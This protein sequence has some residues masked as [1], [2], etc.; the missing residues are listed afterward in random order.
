MSLIKKFENNDDAIDELCACIAI[1]GQAID[2]NFIVL[3]YIAHN[4]P[5]HIE[6]T[7]FDHLKSFIALISNSKI[8][9][10]IITR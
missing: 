6:I 8:T 1:D 9:N 3:L 5:I 7:L 2:N 10:N 4:L